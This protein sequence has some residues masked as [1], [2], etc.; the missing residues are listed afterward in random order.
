MIV[1]PDEMAPF[2]L[3]NK[4][5]KLQEGS[6]TFPIARYVTLQFLYI[7][8]ASHLFFIEVLE[9]IQITDL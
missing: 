7:Y 4:M 1:P 6:S 5:Y 9:E 3:V 8:D 2:C